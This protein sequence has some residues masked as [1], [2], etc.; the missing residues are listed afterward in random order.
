VLST[1]YEEND[2]LLSAIVPAAIAGK[3]EAF[4]EPLPT[5]DSPL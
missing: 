3:L 2:I 5:I 1:T 4:A